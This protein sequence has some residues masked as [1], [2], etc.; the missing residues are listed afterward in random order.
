MTPTFSTIA[1]ARSP[2]KEKFAIPRQPG[3]AT[4][5]KTCIELQPPFDDPAALEGL[6]HISH[7][8]LIFF[9]HGIGSRNDALRVRPPRLGGNERIGVFATR[10]THR[11]NGI[12]QSLVKIEHIETGCITVSGADLL[13]GTPIID[14]KPYVPYA[15]TPV[16]AINHIAP[17]APSLLEVSWQPQATA[18]ALTFAAELNEDVIKVITECLEQDPRPAYQKHEPE[19]VYGV[20]LW[21]INVR[22]R[23]P[24]NDTIEVIDLGHL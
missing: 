4:S 9:F 11:P 14:I 12:G 2:Y 22:W 1:L 5:V 16:D 15:D 23:Y 6:E 10:S 24:T 17:H 20:K 18:Q 13:D 19:R 21:H 8:W 7:I 3:L